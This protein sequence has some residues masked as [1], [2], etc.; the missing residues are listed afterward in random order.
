MTR[1]QKCKA[2]DLV[3]ERFHIYCFPFYLMCSV[4]N[5]SFTIVSFTYAINGTI[6]Y[7]VNDVYIWQNVNISQ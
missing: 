6:Y 1:C 4:L 5:V 7:S 3:N 2:L